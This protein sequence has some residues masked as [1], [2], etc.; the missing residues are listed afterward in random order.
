[1][2]DEGVIDEEEREW[3][4]YRVYGRKYKTSIYAICGDNIYILNLRMRLIRKGLEGI[5][6]F[7]IEKKGSAL[8]FEIGGSKYLLEKLNMYKVRN[9]AKELYESVSELCSEEEESGLSR[10]LLYL[11]QVSKDKVLASEIERYR[12][13][14]LKKPHSDTLAFS[15]RIKR[16]NPLLVI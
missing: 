3:T 8:N 11:Y 9:T 10:I 13:T 14:Y 15:I 12:D 5:V 7:Y 2:V 6:S 4:V 1:M 16:E